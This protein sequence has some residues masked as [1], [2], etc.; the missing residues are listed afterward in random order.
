MNNNTD[1]RS[2]L[3]VN[4]PSD[5]IDGSYSILWGTGLTVFQIG[6]QHPK[7]EVKKVKSVLF[8]VLTVWQHRQE[9]PASY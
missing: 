5:G 9:R 2:I 4:E 1:R 8:A 7:I 6:I 3:S